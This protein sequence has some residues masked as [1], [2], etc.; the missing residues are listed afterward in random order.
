MNLRHFRSF[1]Y[2][3]AKFLGDVQA[4]KSGDPKKMAKRVGRRTAGKATGRMLRKLFK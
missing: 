3:L 2:T 4:V 1:L